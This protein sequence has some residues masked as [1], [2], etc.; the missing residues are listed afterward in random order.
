MTTVAR[1]L[2]KNH[3]N[4]AGAA[5]LMKVNLIHIKDR[6]EAYFY[7]LSVS[8]CVSASAPWCISAID[9]ARNL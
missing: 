6:K 7:P 4:K 3:N 2:K 1:L 5:R 8:A 9:T